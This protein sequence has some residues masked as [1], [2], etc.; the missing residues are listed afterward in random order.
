MAPEVRVEITGLIKVH[1][2]QVAKSIAEVMTRSD[3]YKGLKQKF[4]DSFFEP[5]ICPLLELDWNMYLADKKQELKGEMLQ[6]RGSVVCFVNGQ[7]IGDE[8][9]LSRWAEKQWLFTFYRPPALYAAITD[10]YYQQ[11]LLN[12]GHVF[13]YMDVEIG[14]EAAGRLLFELFSDLCPK[15]CKNFK[16]L[17]TGEAGMSQNQLMLSYK[18][19]LFHRVVPNGWLQGGDITPAGKGNGGESIYGATFGD[20][21]FAVSHNKRGILGMANQGPHS[22]GSQFYITLQPALW[23]DT[24]YVAFGQVVEGT[25]VLRK[26]E[27]VPTYNERPKQDCRIVACGLFNP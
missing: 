8:K 20:E 10:E 1:H 19:S 15:T 21:G 11:H 26:L 2:F 17:C 16:A 5:T 12:T 6:Y 4:P 3:A 13:V 7:F 27:E 23:M 18:N 25:D 14:G 22:N 24:N 9:D